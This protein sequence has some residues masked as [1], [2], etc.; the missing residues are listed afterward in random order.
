MTL[1]GDGAVV[2]SV[3]V[4]DIDHMVVVVVLAVVVVV[5]ADR[6]V[7]NVVVVVLKV[8][9]DHS[10]A[11]AV[12]QSYHHMDLCDVVVVVVDWVVWFVVVAV[13]VMMISSVFRDSCSCCC[14]CCFD[15][16]N[17]DCCSLFFLSC[18]RCFT[19]NQKVFQKRENGDGENCPKSFAMLL[20]LMT[21]TGQIDFEEFCV[22]RSVF[23]CELKTN[24]RY[25]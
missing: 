13:V 12:D 16:K 2:G 22:D 19:L 17:F 11:V 3:V 5:A 25:Q 21:M 4:V 10:V 7:G 14:C 24:V 1:H 18:F 23:V 20:L 15:W 8:A 9:I 6:D